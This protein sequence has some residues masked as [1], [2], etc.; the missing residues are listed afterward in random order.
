M[1]TLLNAATALIVF[2]R[3]AVSY[4]KDARYV[5]AGIGVENNLR[6][7]KRNPSAGNSWGGTGTRSS[8]ND[9]AGVRHKLGI[10]RSTLESKIRSL[11]IN[12][13]RYKHPSGT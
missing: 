12:K 6:R 11:N 1:R 9:V 3:A 13:N 2:A 5:R 4:P 10:A 8:A 7:L